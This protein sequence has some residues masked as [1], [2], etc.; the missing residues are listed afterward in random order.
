MN[1]LYYILRRIGYSGIVLLG[2]SILVFI[3]SHVI[4]GDP[5]RLALGPMAKEEQVQKL[6]HK[7]W[8]DHPLPI[9][10]THYI[11]R[12]LQ[13][14][15][16]E[17]LVTRR[18]VK[19]DLV[20]YLPATLELV[21]VT[22]FLIVIV[23]IPL[24]VLSARYKDTMLDNTIRIFATL[25]VVTPEFFMA[26]ILQLIFGYWLNILP[27]LGR[28]TYGIQP[29]A[30]I[31]GLY[32]FDSLTVFNFNVFFDALSHLIL[33]SLSLALTGIGQIVR[34]TRASI[35]DVR[36]KDYVEAERSYGIPEFVVFFKYMLKPSF[37]P[38]MTILGMIFASLF[39]NAFLVEMIFSWPGI[40]SYGIRAIL[41][42]DFSGIIGVVMIIGLA[43]VVINLVVDLLAGYF[44]PR[45][46][47]KGESK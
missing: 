21:L 19:R 34:I 38:T 26:L 15:F 10:Y 33:P 2:L 1:Y 27:I 37:I 11:T 25:S 44:D 41:N 23:G 45:I 43:F 7:L 17:S 3:I 12:I 32:L 20:S 31:T 36:R 8:L 18:A 13:G 47:I 22:I 6:R 39:G 14:N 42:K 40:A 24:G 46:R 30:R 4:P 16:G 29:P 5:A 35:I 28:V 9:Q